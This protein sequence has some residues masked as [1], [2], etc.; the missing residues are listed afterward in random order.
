MQIK[1]C[2]GSF[3]ALARFQYG[4]PSKS[5]KSHGVLPTLMLKPKI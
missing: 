3:L 5:V 2:H 4:Y 1:A